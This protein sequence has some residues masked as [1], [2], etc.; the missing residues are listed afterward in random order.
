MHF[1]DRNH[2]RPC[3]RCEH[4]AGDIEDTVHAVCMRGG[5]LR[6]Q[7]FGATGCVFWVRA[8]GTDNEDSVEL[9]RG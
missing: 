2:D 7:T 1:Q 8:I 5:E 4:W 6:V 9:A 3:W